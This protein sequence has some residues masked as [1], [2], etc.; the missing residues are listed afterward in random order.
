MQNALEFR[1]N[2]TIPRTYMYGYVHY[3]HTCLV[4]L[5]AAE[6][7]TPMYAKYFLEGE[8]PN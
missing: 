7:D 2:S 5:D 1:C 3:I 6:T 4:C 8:W